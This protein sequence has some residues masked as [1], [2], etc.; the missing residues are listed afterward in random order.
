MQRR[1]SSARSGFSSRNVKKVTAAITDPTQA[2]LP[3]TREQR[4]NIQNSIVNGINDLRT[5]VFTNVTEERRLKKHRLHV[6]MIFGDI[7]VVVYN[8]SQSYRLRRTREQAKK[9]ADDLRWCLEVAIPAVES[10]RKAAL[11]AG[12]NRLVCFLTPVK[13]PAFQVLDN[14]RVRSQR[15]GFGIVPLLRSSRNGRA[16]PGR[17]SLLGLRVPH[18]QVGGASISPQ[19][20]Q[21]HRCLG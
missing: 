13:L 10:T 6:S 16:D 14:P 2:S 15:R 12:S 11:Q 5:G 1:W 4:M 19:A 7:E 8:E 20:E 3:I 17:Q 9:M 21:G 18:E